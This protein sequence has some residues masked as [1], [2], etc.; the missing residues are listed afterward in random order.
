MNVLSVGKKGMVF[1]Y[2]IGLIY[3]SKHMKV[4]ILISLDHF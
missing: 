4:S 1:S 2:R 3:I